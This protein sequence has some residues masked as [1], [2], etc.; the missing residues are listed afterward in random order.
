MR[1]IASFQRCDSIYLWHLNPNIYST[2]FWAMAQ[3]VQRQK[4]HMLSFF[5]NL[6][7]TITLAYV[8]KS[9]RQ[10]KDIPVGRE[11]N[12]PIVLT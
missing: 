8:F 10:D 5:N 12:E 2:V 7:C 1:Y 4:Q 9:H 6:F 11:G 3:Q